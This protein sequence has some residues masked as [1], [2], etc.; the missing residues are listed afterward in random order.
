M[1]EHVGR[2]LGNY[3]IIRLLGQGGFAAVYLGEHIYLKTQAAVKVLHTRLSGRNDMDDF[4]REAQL[5]AHLVDSNIVRIMD[6]GVD[7]DVPFLVMDYAPN[8]TLRQRHPYGMRLPLVTILPYVKHVATALQYA[9]DERLVHRDVKPE[10]MLLGRHDEVLLSDFGLACVVQSSRHSARDVVGTVAYMSPEQIQGK[11]QPASDQY[12]LGVVVYEWLTGEHPFR[13]T[14]TELCTQHMFA[15]VPSLSKKNRHISPQVEQVVLMALA[16]DPKLRFSSVQAFADALEQ[17]IHAKTA[18][19]VLAK[20]PAK[21]LLPNKLL[22]VDEYPM[23]RQY[24]V[25]FNDPQRKM[26]AWTIGKRQFIAM[27]IGTSLYSIVTYLI[28][29]ILVSGNLMYAPFGG[30]VLSPLILQI[31][32]YLILLALGLTIP[33][34]FAAKFGPW[35]GFVCTTFG[36]LIGSAL[37]RSIVLFP[38]FF[39][40]SFGLSGFLTGLVF[41]RTQGHYSKGSSLVL[42]SVASFIAGAISV[43]IVVVGNTISS[44]QFY[45]GWLYIA[46]SFYLSLALTNII[47]ALLLPILL[48]ISSKIEQRNTRAW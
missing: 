19:A 43:I 14:F 6:F 7:G 28:D 30:S 5:I 33:F 31:S 47:Q 27:L 38:W 20:N 39:Y 21:K 17:A 46:L 18:S 1:T 35:V 3:Y 13:G 34:F 44:H 48:L 9:H 26:N 45:Q 29:G 23:A 2:R 12:S 10:N 11:P 40:V 24:P 22:N 4:L 16:K 42:A 8:G 36:A 15:P 37:S 41:L 25:A 32:P